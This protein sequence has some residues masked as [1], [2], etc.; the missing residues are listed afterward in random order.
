M[1]WHITVIALVSKTGR[2]R[3]DCETMGKASGDKKLPFVFTGKLYHNIFPERKRIFADIHSNIQNFSGNYTHQFG[4]SVRGCL[5]VKPPNDPITGKRFVILYPVTADTCGRI[6]CFIPR[7][8]KIASGISEYMRFNNFY[9]RYVSID[10]FH[11]NYFLFVIRSKYLPYSV[12]CI[13]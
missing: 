12:F 13:F 10:D 2:F 8:K 3:E 5:I 4:L 11:E 1:R 7:F 6:F 9:I